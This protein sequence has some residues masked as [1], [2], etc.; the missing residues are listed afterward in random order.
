MFKAKNFGSL[1]TLAE[2]LLLNHNREVELYLP[3]NS[4]IVPAYYDCRIYQYAPGAFRIHNS[5]IEGNSDFK[6]FL[7]PKFNLQFATLALPG[8][9]YGYDNDHLM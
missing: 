1:S 8:F 7:V 6:F 4:L 3:P 9:M 5:I 2:E